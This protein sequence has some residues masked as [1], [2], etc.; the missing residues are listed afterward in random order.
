MPTLNTNNL[1]LVIKANEAAKVLKS[2]EG[3]SRYEG[4]A[5][6]GMVA[7]GGGTAMNG[8]RRGRPLRAR[9][10]D[11]PS[12]VTPPGPSFPLASAG[13]KQAEVGVRF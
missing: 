10:R 9:R 6:T 5:R 7:A 11:V 3:F 1:M 12:L 8:A 13:S 2:V 4:G